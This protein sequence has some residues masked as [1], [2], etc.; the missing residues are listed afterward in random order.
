MAY[1][2]GS[3]WLEPYKPKTGAEVS[4]RPV[5]AFAR[6]RLV[7]PLFM[8]HKFGLCLALIAPPALVLLLYALSPALYRAQTN[9]IIATKLEHQA[10]SNGAR[11]DKLRVPNQELINAE[12]DLLANAVVV[13]Q[14]LAHFGITE[15]YPNF[16]SSQNGSQMVWDAAVRQF[17]SSLRVVPNQQSGM[18]RLTFEHPNAGTAAEA[19]N[20]FILSY[21]ASREKILEGRNSRI[22]AAAVLRDAKDLEQLER[23]RDEM[24]AAIGTLDL[25]QQR[26]ALIR[27]RADTDARLSQ[28]VERVQA[29]S[30][31]LADLVQIHSEVVADNPSNQ[32]SNQARISH[33]RNETTDKP[34][35]AAMAQPRSPLAVV[36]DQPAGAGAKFLSAQPPVQLA[37]RSLKQL[38][39]QDQGVPTR[40]ITGT[41]LAIH[42][43]RIAQ[44]LSD[45]DSLEHQVELK[46]TLN[47]VAT[48]RPKAMR[49]TDTG[50]Q[51]RRSDSNADYPATAIDLTEASKK[52]GS[53]TVVM[54]TETAPATIR[55]PETRVDVN[56]RQFA[57][58]ASSHDQN[59]ILIQRLRHWLPIIQ[60]QA[61]NLRVAKANLP[62][63]AS[64]IITAI[65][66]DRI[67][68]QAELDALKK[69]KIIDTVSIGLID[70][71]LVRLGQAN[72]RLSLLNARIADQHERVTAAQNLYD[73]AKAAEGRN[74]AGIA[75]A[76]W[77]LNDTVSV[78]PVMPI[79]L[80][81]ASAVASLLLAAAILVVSGVLAERSLARKE[82][83]ELFLDAPKREAE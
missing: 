48:G 47:A 18:I 20:Q 25:S 36:Q 72:L 30:V 12:A 69:Q 3:Q 9:I 29:L 76:I 7:I 61:A 43:A 49:R 19:L 40:L 26:E 79:T 55:V 34:V 27:Q 62:I 51:P 66:Q 10:S 32:A 71:Q 44:T 38:M 31:H 1:Q 13:E 37:S 70:Q 28:T 83:L 67:G 33:I 46:P 54:L 41:G 16:L 24:R 56:P 82:S 73:N 6:H 23:A 14:T 35:R 53:G 68:A 50:E 58:L 2:A 65:D 15:L 8:Q 11:L 42:E 78:R 60:E 39:S 4:E 52:S 80:A 17:Q 57:V 5:E 75:E 77:P 45:L 21:Q 63:A 64:T 74:Q 81:L 59:D 22:T